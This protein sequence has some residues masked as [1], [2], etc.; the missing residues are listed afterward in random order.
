MWLIGRDHLRLYQ[1]DMM[2]LQAVKDFRD[3]CASQ[4]RETVIDHSSLD[5]CAMGLYADSLLVS[6]LTV[7]CNLAKP[8]SE[9]CGVGF[10]NTLGSIIEAPIEFPTFGVLTIKLNARIIAYEAEHA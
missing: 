3:F 8:M 4:G 2:N 6:S 5:S 9:V 10:Y 7:G 1:G